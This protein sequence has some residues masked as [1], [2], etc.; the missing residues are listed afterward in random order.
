MG[1]DEVSYQDSNTENGVYLDSS[2]FQCI[3]FQ[4]FQQTSWHTLCDHNLKELCVS[5]FL[6]WLPTVEVYK[7]YCDTI[8]YVLY[9]SIIV[10]HHIFELMLIKGLI[11]Q[12]QMMPLFVKKRTTFK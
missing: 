4:A 1:D 11:F 9:I 6:F 12:I 7:S 8:L 5:F 2:S 3:R 10:L